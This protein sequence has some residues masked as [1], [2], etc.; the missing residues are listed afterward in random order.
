[1]SQIAVTLNEERVRLIRLRSTNASSKGSSVEIGDLIQLS[2]G[3]NLVPKDKWDKAKENPALALL[4]KTAIPASPAPEANPERVGRM[5]IVE[6]KELP[7]ESPLK[8]LSA[9]AAKD[10]ITETLDTTLLKSWLPDEG[11]AEV[12]KAIER[13]ITTIE[14]PKDS[15]PAGKQPRNTAGKE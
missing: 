9:A 8:G 7:D 12:R 10:M 3:L 6:G 13:Q 15:T 11:R 14:Q 5:I 1:M 2:P 4:L